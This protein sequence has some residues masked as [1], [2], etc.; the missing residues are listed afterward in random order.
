[1][2]APTN[3]T[4]Y[5]VKLKD[6]FT[7]ADRTMAFQFEKPPGFTFRP[8]QW[9]D[10]TLLNPSETDAEGNSRTLSLAS[11][12][13]ENFLLVAT[14]LRDTAFKRELPR[15]PLG[16]EVRIEGPSGSLT[17]HNNATRAAIFI[18][19]GIG[20]T[21]VRSILLRAAHDRLPHRLLVFYSN[22]RPE[23]AAFL[24]ELTALQKE[25]P[26]YRLIPVMTAATGFTNTWTGEKGHVTQKLLAKHQGEAVSPIYYV[27]GPPGMVNGVHEMLN[28]NGVDDDNI[29]ME[30]FGGY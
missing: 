4:Q 16:A 18:V 23:D 26:N 24:E 28:Q 2:S 15:L 14:R 12:P 30:D 19:G 1:M 17:L 10:L 9:I 6:R 11:A 8:G 20:I 21:P 22:R 3:I 29:R 13:H 25:N 27:V 5:Q 7:V